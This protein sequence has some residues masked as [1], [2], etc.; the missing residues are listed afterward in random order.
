MKKIAPL[1]HGYYDKKRRIH[2]KNIKKLLGEDGGKHNFQFSLSVNLTFF[3]KQLIPG[4][5][6]EQFETI[7]QHPAW[8]STLE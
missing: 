1:I 3:R 8:K 2:Y 5:K 6:N 7:E 4:P